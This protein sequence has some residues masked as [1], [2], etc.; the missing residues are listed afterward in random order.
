MTNDVVLSSVVL[1]IVIPLAAGIISRAMLLRSHDPDWI[2][3]VFLAR[4]K[5]FTIIALLATLVIIFAF[6]GEVILSKPFHILLI[7]VPLLIQVYFNAG[8]AYWLAWR[9]KVPFSIAAPAAL[10]GSSNFFELAV[11]TSI[12]LF[13]HHL[14]RDVGVRGRRAYRSARHALGMLGVQPKPGMVCG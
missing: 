8:L 1:Y 12:S 14:G 9:L 7:A 13:G 6:Q 11:A 2:Q 3:N 10:I 4:L 5:P